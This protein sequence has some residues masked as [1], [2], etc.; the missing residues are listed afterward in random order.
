MAKHK[1]N[2][3]LESEERKME[4]NLK[5]RRIKEKRNIHKLKISR[6]NKAEGEKISVIIIYQAYQAKENILRKKKRSSSEGKTLKKATLIVV[7]R[8]KLSK[9]R[10]KYQEKHE[11]ENIYQIAA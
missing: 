4:K 11:I 2:M 7:K 1:R 6:E 8:E 3:A 9:L 10:K 5:R